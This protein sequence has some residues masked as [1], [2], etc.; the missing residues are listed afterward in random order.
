[1]CYL[2]P[3]PVKHCA[4]GWNGVPCNVYSIVHVYLGFGNTVADHAVPNSVNSNSYR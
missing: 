3:I 2:D 4:V 1:M